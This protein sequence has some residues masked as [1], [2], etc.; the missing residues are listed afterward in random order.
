MK[1]TIIVKVSDLRSVIQDVRRSG[2]DTV[3]L[4]ILE[5]EQEDGYT[6]P[7][8]ISIEGCKSFEPDTWFDFDD[9]DAVPNENELIQKSVKAF[10]VSDNLIDF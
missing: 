8:S 3:S 2:C 9:V 6:T 4:S 7:A 5:G 10:H 1:D